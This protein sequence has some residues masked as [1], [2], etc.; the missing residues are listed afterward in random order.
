MKRHA[1]D[2][3]G[4]GGLDGPDPEQADV[5]EGEEGEDDGDDADVGMSETEDENGEEEETG[6]EGETE[7]EETPTKKDE[8]KKDEIELDQKA[9]TMPFDEKEEML[10]TPRPLIEAQE[11]LCMEVRGSFVLSNTVSSSPISLRVKSH[12]SDKML[13]F[14]ND[15]MT[16]GKML[17]V[18]HCAY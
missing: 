10:K 11:D 12:T 4:G 2:Y 1:K 17:I 14:R 7:G 3:M 6:G 8:S 5:E 9:V 18:S 16:R 15:F 13:L